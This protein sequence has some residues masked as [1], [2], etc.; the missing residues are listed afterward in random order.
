MEAASDCMHKASEALSAGEYDRAVSIMN[1]LSR[2]VSHEGVNGGKRNSTYA[3]EHDETSCY[4]K[5][6]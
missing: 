5:D 3:D 4:G 1:D 6:S 2:A